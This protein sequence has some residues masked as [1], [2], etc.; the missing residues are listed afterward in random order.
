[1]AC[2]GLKTYYSYVVVVVKERRKGFMTPVAAKKLLA[3]KSTIRKLQ[4]PVNLQERQIRY[5]K[6]THIQTA[7]RLIG[8]SLGTQF[9]QNG[10]TLN[11]A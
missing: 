11:R 9:A 3:I 7:A 1:M 4:D 8:F 2:L 5:V 10:R 6:N